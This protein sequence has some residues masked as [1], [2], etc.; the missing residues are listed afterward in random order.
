MTPDAPTLAPE[1]PSLA[2][3]PPFRARRTPL[4]RNWALVLALGWPVADYLARALEPLPANPGA[5]APVLVVA[6]NYALLLG[7]LAV[8]VAAARRQWWAPAAGAAV[9][10]LGLA[11]AVAC[12]VSGHHQ[13][14]LWWVAQLGL[15]GGMT[16][17]SLA[18]LRR[19]PLNV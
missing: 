5:A 19:S 10:L 15:Y 14:G 8:V 7:L 16:A 17:A 1:H 4:S 3:S 6:V 18:A 13:F 2:T 12:P 11:L 9:G